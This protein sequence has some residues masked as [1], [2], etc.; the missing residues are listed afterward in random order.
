MTFSTTATT[1][2]ASAKSAP[3]RGVPIRRM[4]G[5]PCDVEV[6]ISD[7][8]STDPDLPTPSRADFRALES[9]WEHANK[10]DGQPYTV[11]LIPTQGPG[12]RAVPASSAHPC[13]RAWV[14]RQERRRL[15]TQ[16]ARI[17][18]L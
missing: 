16:P 18:R 15:V 5:E 12:E 14:T 9:T 4:S 2:R 6:K 10:G 17:T 13:L 7:A 8:V 1:P 11:G 3:S